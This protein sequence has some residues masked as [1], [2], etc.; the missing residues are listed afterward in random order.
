MFA[1][2]A[3]AFLI[4]FAVAVL[5]TPAVMRLAHRVNALDIPNARKVHKSPVPRFGGPVLYI[6]IVFALI[7]SALTVRFTGWD[8]CSLCT[9]AP[10][11]LAGATLVLAVGIV[12]DVLQVRAAIKLA[13]E[14]VASLI[15][16]GGGLQ[17]TTLSH[18]LGG[19]PIPLGWLSAPVT[20]L[21]IIGVTNATNL[22]DGLDGLASGIG[23]IVSSTICFLAIVA[24][25]LGTALLAV[26]IAGTL[27]GFLRFNVFPARIFLGDSGSLLLGFSLACLSVLGSVKGPT[28]FGF[29][30]PMVALGLPLMDTFLA[31]LRR[32]MPAFRIGHREEAV[33][34]RHLFANLAKPD[35]EHI[36]HRLLQLGVPHKRAVAILLA[37]SGCLGLGALAIGL[38]GTAAASIIGVSAGVAVL[39][40]M[41]NLGARELTFLR[42]SIFLPLYNWRGLESRGFQVAVDLGFVFCAYILAALLGGAALSRGMLLVLA[43]VAVLQVLLLVSMK[44]YRIAIRSGNTADAVLLV[45]AALMASLTAGILAAVVTSG[46]GSKILVISVFD[47]FFLSTFLLASRYSYRAIRHMSVQYRIG[48]KHVLI[49]GTGANALRTLMHLLDSR[50]ERYV[51]VGFLDDDPEMERKVFQ[52]YPVFGGHWKIEGLIPRYDIKEIIVAEENLKPEVFARL[53]EISRRKG[54]AVKSFAVRLQ[55]IT[56]RA[57]HVATPEAPRIPS[58]AGK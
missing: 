10:Y 26:A 50:L 34:L 29:A 35:K 13:V 47:F 7:C 22:I 18:P 6:G 27:V 19:A 11:L 55:P 14:I 53:R 48:A 45:R 39:F 36:H 41:R 17:I 4:S 51:P 44:V 30:V 58:F 57:I 40:G 15:V 2:L 25:D 24:G 56:T 28:A 20:V 38:A 5:L 31:I 3:Q 43:G 8:S 33:P 16:V 46:L 32:S 54:V 37:V 42:N 23:V 21:W 9:V 1:H 49:Y 52:G 12:D